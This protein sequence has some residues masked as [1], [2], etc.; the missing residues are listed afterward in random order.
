MANKF[1]NIQ[2]IHL[3]LMYQLV[4]ADSNESG[5]LTVC[6]VKLNELQF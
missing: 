2:M 1:L 5:L 6:Q 4:A 3:A